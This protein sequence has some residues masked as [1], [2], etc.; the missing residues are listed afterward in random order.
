MNEKI[1][2]LLRTFNHTP[3]SFEFMLKQLQKRTLDPFIENIFST[4]DDGRLYFDIDEKYKESIDQGWNIFKEKFPA[5]IKKYEMTYKNFIENKILYEK[6]EYK[7]K[8]LLTQYTIEESLKCN[9]FANVL[10]KKTIHNMRAFNIESKNDFNPRFNSGE[11]LA[12]VFFGQEHRLLG[13]VVNNENEA[14]PS[15]DVCDI[16]INDIEPTEFSICDFFFGQFITPLFE[17]LII[18]YNENDNKFGIYINNYGEEKQDF[19]R[20]S[21][22]RDLTEEEINT[23]FSLSSNCHIQNDDGQLKLW[24]VNSAKKLC[25]SNITI[26]K[27]NISFSQKV[28]TNFEFKKFYEQKNF[29][30]LKENNIYTLIYN[31]NDTT[32]V[33]ITSND[34]INFDFLNLNIKMLQNGYEGCY[35]YSKKITCFGIIGRNGNFNLMFSKENNKKSNSSKIAR[36]ELNINKSLEEIGAASFPKDKKIKLVLSINFNDWLLCSTSEN[37]TSC[38]NFESHFKAAHYQGLFGLLGDPNRI[39]IYFTDGT[40]KEYEGI[41]SKKMFTRS[42]ALLDTTDTFNVVKFYPFN[43]ILTN[44]IQEITNIKF[45]DI[46]DGFITKNPIHLLEYRYKYD[47]AYNFSC[48]IYQDKTHFSF[49][50]KDDIYLKYNGDKGYYTLIRELST[51]NLYQEKEFSF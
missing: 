42:W 11:S 19:N 32:L 35:S 18:G 1:I 29:S 44:K 6:N 23:F 7:I 2:E 30:I 37:W 48:F 9:D 39:M 12:I 17:T 49:K 3:E 31:E 25:F 36:I 26:D 8:K 51:G 21:K 16:V 50:N 14:I 4:S 43:I 28:E 15:F 22:L 20:L 46:D 41:I 10:S 13:L 27:K 33:S 34:G 24:F 47:K 45:I 40:P 38:L 5:F